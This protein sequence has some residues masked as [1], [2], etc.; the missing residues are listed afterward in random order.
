MSSCAVR[1]ADRLMGV[2]E[3]GAEEA[4]YI[5]GRIG[6]AR[7]RRRGVS[8][9]GAARVGTRVASGGGQRP[10]KPAHVGP[11]QVMARPSPPL[12]HPRPAAT[13]DAARLLHA[14]PRQRAR[15]PPP[16]WRPTGAPLPWCVPCSS[17]FISCRITW[18]VTERSGA[19]PAS[20]VQPSRDVPA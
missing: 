9:P 13:G 10:G 12:A 20:G 1:L 6:R 8:G 17:A 7:G 11:G 4:A 18:D 5:G 2:E 15:S 16:R 3:V 19:V 14:S